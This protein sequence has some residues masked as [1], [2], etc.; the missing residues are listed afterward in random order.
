MFKLLSLDT[1]R[2]GFSFFFLFPFWK[3]VNKEKLFQ[4]YF[5]GCAKIVKP[6]CKDFKVSVI[7]TINV[8]Y[9]ILSGKSLQ[10]SANHV[11]VICKSVQIIFKSYLIQCKCYEIQCKYYANQWNSVEVIYKSM[12]LSAIHL[13][14]GHSI[15]T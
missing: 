3:G 2:E 12:Q 10:V 5:Q 13:Q 15:T 14:R 1:A 6:T 9:L 7:V 8:S 11:Q 4:P